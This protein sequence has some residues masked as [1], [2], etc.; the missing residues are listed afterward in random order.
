MMH[1]Y[2]YLLSN[3]ARHERFNE[4]EWLLDRVLKGYTK[5][6]RQYEKDGSISV[7]YSKTEVDGEKTVLLKRN[8]TE[9]NTSVFSDIPLKIFRF[10]GWIFYLRD[11][12]PS[13][14]F[15]LL[16]YF[17]AVP[18]NDRLINDEDPFSKLL[19]IAGGSAAGLVIYMLTRRLVSTERSYDRICFVQFGGFFMIIQIL[20][21][22]VEHPRVGAYNF[23][24]YV[25]GLTPFI[26]AVG[27]LVLARLLHKFESDTK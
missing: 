9:S 3:L 13:L 23:W 16:Y 1:T 8:V 11:I 2:G 25:L 14:A 5:G 7:T 21:V 15:F 22:M 12:I 27:G 18:I 17:C 19:A 4:A 26:E 20:S 24:I 6:N 10:G